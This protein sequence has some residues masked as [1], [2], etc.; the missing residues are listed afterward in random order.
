MP[1]VSQPSGGQ[2]GFAAPLL[3]LLDSRAPVIEQ[4]LPGDTS[5]SRKWSQVAYTGTG[6]AFAMDTDLGQSS[7][8]AG[9]ARGT[10]WI[11]RP[12]A[13]TGCLRPAEAAISPPS[14][15]VRVGLLRCRWST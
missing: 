14:I 11:G 13:N 1:P 4:R 7:G 8:R 12:L 10:R 15:G 3:E 5:G 9:P 6:R 2:Q